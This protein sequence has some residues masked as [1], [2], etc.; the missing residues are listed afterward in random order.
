MAGA[1]IAYALERG[2]L[3][4]SVCCMLRPLEIF[5]REIACLPI[6]IRS[7]AG[8]AHPQ[9]APAGFSSPVPRQSLPHLR[10]T[11]LF[12]SPSPDTLFLVT[13]GFSMGMLFHSPILHRQLCGCKIIPDKPVRLGRKLAKKQTRPLGLRGGKVQC[14]MHTLLGNSAPDSTHNDSY[15]PGQPPGP[16]CTRGAQAPLNGFSVVRSTQ[17]WLERDEVG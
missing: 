7:I 12:S 10:Q 4:L 5:G 1:V 13:S 15:K 2:S 16:S 11:R 9:R 14:T 8:D 6:C 3:H 17:Q